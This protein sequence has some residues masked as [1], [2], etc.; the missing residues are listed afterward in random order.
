M[1]AWLI[2]AIT[3]GNQLSLRESMDISSDCYEKLLS[4]PEIYQPVDI[5]GFRHLKA[6]R[7][8]LDRL[9]LIENDMQTRGGTVLEIGSC[10]GFFSFQLADR[11]YSVKAYDADNRNI[12]LCQ[13]IARLRCAAY[14]PEFQALTLSLDSVARLRG[15][16]YVLCLAVFHH[17]IY[18]YGYD[19]ARIILR[20]IKERTRKTLYFEMGQ[21]NEDEQYWTQ[22]LSVMAG[23]PLETIPSL[24]RE[25]GYSNIRLLGFV[26]TH[27]SSTERCLFAADA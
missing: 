24:L 9:A 19:A 16:E 11:A 21:H 22:S 26:Q 4:L 25:A 8:C 3:R 13:M 12:E 15:A 17:L 5:M 20:Q 23:D 1:L 18:D 6:K 27:L 14:H 2:G 10:L 7:P